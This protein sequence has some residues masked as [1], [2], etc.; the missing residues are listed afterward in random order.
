M[1]HVTQQDTGSLDQACPSTWNLSLFLLPTVTRQLHGQKLQVHLSSSQLTLGLPTSETVT[2]SQQLRLCDRDKVPLGLDFQEF[3]A[4]NKDKSISKGTIPEIIFLLSLDV[5]IFVSW[6]P[7]TPAVASS[8]L[9]WL[10]HF[11]AENPAMHRGM[12]YTWD[13]QPDKPKQRDKLRACTYIHRPL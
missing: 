7:R 13:P 8:G 5:G 11:T 3:V 9:Q 10:S 12:G 1:T 2:L 6:H 4:G